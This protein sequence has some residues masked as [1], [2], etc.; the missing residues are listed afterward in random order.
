MSS[1]LGLPLAKPRCQEEQ[2]E[3][4]AKWGELS[5]L[6]LD[7]ALFR[8]VYAPKDFLEIL[9]QIQSPNLQPPQLAAPTAAEGGNSA[10][11]LQWG[12]L[13]LPLKVNKESNLVSLPG[14]RW[15]DKVRLWREFPAVLRGRGKE[16]YFSVRGRQ[17]ENIPDF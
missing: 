1:E 3:L 14:H 9:A 13:S 5:T 8:P 2:D 11:S 6:D 16:G 7:L 15:L 17:R 12:L 10:S 4:Q